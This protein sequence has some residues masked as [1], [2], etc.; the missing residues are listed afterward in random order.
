MNAPPKPV[1]NRPVE[2]GL[3]DLQQCAAKIQLRMAAQQQSGIAPDCA[4]HLDLIRNL[5]AQLQAP[6]CQISH[7]KGRELHPNEIQTIEWALRL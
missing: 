4:P 2:Y 1:L 3:E 5:I 6:H 7:Y